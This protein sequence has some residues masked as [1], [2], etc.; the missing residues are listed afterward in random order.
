[1]SSEGPD[2]SDLVKGTTGAAIEYGETRIKELVKK[3]RNRELS[4]INDP[5]T[6]EIVKE[7]IRTSEFKLTSKYVRD[8]EL[9]LI[10]QMG[11]TLRQLEKEKQMDKV[12]KLKGDIHRKYKSWGVHAAQAVQAGIVIGFL[13]LFI[14]NITD[15]TELC[16]AIEDI[17]INIDKL[18]VYVKEEHEVEYLLKRIETI[19]LAHNPQAMLICSKYSANKV[20]E[21]LIKELESELVDYNMEVK[22]SQNTIF[23]AL[24]RKDIHCA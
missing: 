15:E 3:F 17:L 22:R 8:R 5:S 7:Q 21:R 12:L 16:Y 14:D 13:E 9:Q 2:Y 24:E 18:V 11:L 20:M 4:F 1:M 23:T 6:I 19:L 10:V